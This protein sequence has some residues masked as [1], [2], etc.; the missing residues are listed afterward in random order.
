LVPSLSAA[1]AEEYIEK[2]II[3]GGMVPKVRSALQAV[4]YGA[5]KVRIVNLPGLLAGEGTT[6]VR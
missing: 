3:N 1:E 6:I 4:A 5:D 2:G